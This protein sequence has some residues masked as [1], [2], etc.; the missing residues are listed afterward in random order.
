MTL[1]KSEAKKTSADT[2][3]GRP[4]RPCSMSHAHAEHH[5]PLTWSRISFVGVR[6]SIA[7]AGVLSSLVAG[8]EISPSSRLRRNTSVSRM[9]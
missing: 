8:L 9:F 6:G 1:A 7:A 5:M 4:R 2:T 3:P